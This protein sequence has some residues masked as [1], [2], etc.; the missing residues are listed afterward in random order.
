MKAAGLQFTPVDFHFVVITGTYNKVLPYIL[1]GSLT[2][3]SSVVNFFLPETFNK[4]LPETVEQ[5]QKCRGYLFI[6]LLTY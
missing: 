5:M 1:M 2:I 4:D 6:Y 3:A